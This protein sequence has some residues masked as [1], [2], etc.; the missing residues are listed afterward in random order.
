MLIQRL[1]ESMS[2]FYKLLSEKMLKKGQITQEDFEKLV[3]SVELRG[4]AKLLLKKIDKMPV[5]SLYD[6]EDQ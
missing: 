4:P 6:N 3:P 2:G 1:R 5:D